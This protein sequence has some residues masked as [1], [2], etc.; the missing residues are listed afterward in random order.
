MSRI[1]YVPDRKTRRQSCF[2]AATPEFTFMFV[3]RSIFEKAK[4]R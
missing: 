1:F 3:L 2:V 4:Q